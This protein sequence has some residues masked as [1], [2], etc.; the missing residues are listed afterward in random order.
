MCSQ[1]G[2]GFR[3]RHVSFRGLYGTI[4]TKC[5]KQGLEITYLVKFSKLKVNLGPTA[6]NRKV[7]GISGLE[8]SR[9]FELSLETLETFETM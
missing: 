7:S 5:S 9:L 2:V 4:E 6:R 3:G 1:K 8:T